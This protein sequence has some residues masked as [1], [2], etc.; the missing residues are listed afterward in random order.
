MF[1]PFQVV[2]ERPGRLQTIGFLGPTLPGSLQNTVFADPAHPG[3]LHPNL[4]VDPNP[5]GR[6][7][8]NRSADPT[9]T[10]GRLHTGFGDWT[11]SGSRQAHFLFLH[12]LERPGGLQTIGLVLHHILLVYRMKVCGQPLTG[13]Y[14]L[15]VSKPHCQCLSRRHWR[16]LLVLVLTENGEM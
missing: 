11:I 6:L 4:F 8:S 13:D 5:T 15:L 10:G 16:P 7:E 12:C 14:N 1:E 9:Q 3:D 2:P